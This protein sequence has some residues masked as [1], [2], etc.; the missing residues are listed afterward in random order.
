M[1]EDA[2]R[3]LDLVQNETIKILPIRFIKECQR[4]LTN[5]R[6]W[7]ISRQLW[8]GHRI[9]AYKISKGTF[10]EWIVAESLEDA[11]RT[12]SDSFPDLEGEFGVEQDA[13]V[14]DTWFSSSL[15]PFSVF[16]WPNQNMDDLKTFY[17]GSLLETGHDILFFW[18]IRMIIMS[19]KL[20]NQIPFKQV[21]LHGLIRD[22]HGRK[23]S[24]SLGNII[25]PMH[26]INGITLEKLYESLLEYNLS[27][28]EIELAKAGQRSDFPNGIPECGTDA[29]RF[30]FL[31][32]CSQTSDVNLDI[33]R[34]QGYRHF[35][36]KLWQAFRFSV[37]FAFPDPKTQLLPVE[38]VDWIGSTSSS[39]ILSRLAYCAMESN[40]A[41]DQYD[42]SRYAT[43][44]Y[45]FWLYE[46]C[47]VFIELVKPHLKQ[48]C[49][50]QNDTGSIIDIRKIM[51]SVLYYCV[52]NGLRLLH[53]AMPF[54]TE[55]LFNRLPP[56]NIPLK[57][58][59]SIDQRSSVKSLMMSSYPEYNNE[60]EVFRNPS[61]EISFQLAQQ[62]I[63]KIRRVFKDIGAT[64][65]TTSV[66]I[67]AKEEPSLLNPELSDQLLN[68]IA[69]LSGCESIKVVRAN[70]LSEDS[71]S[72]FTV[73][74]EQINDDYWIYL[75]QNFEK[76]ELN[77]VNLSK[78]LQ[79]SDLN[80]IRPD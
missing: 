56:M 30:A 26:V 59:W 9:P 22:S 24:K 51:A 34:I 61:I 46:L 12:A 1:K 79:A 21:Y 16:G 77:L 4:W 15:F 6:D 54:I 39:W 55:E 10:T 63:T 65:E 57:D 32:Y 8:W 71:A 29:L 52:I 27:S 31:T 76:S 38:C 74:R 64:K 58:D 47:D 78:E 68:I 75:S 53:P 3:A 50:D 17:P 66:R 42:F 14:L 18:V 20:N 25:D 41:L 19:L 72:S 80:A 35:C 60:L 67:C 40:E 43:A 28:K 11:R 48:Q 36:N 69:H 13:D 2:V 44:I 23:M 49:N 70:T 45:N 62:F 37:E 7:C 73:I 33:L 5:C